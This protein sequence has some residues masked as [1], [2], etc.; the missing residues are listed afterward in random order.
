MKRFSVLLLLLIVLPLVSCGSVE[1]VVEA[2]A[3]DITAEATDLGE[4][5]DLVE[6]SDLAAIL[7]RLDIAPEDQGTMTDAN[8]RV[9]IGTASETAGDET[10]LTET[11]VIVTVMIYNAAGAA[12]TGFNETRD[13]LKTVLGEDLAL[14]EVNAATVGDQSEFWS[15]K[16]SNQEANVYL[17]LGRRLNVLIVVMTVGPAEITQTWVLSL[18]QTLINR[19]PVPVAE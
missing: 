12:Q 3:V 13:S 8:R 4:G 14:V 18:G 17:F 2:N 11:Q 16:E 7:E 5:F 1:P 15:A 10:P 19:V 6:E 9:F